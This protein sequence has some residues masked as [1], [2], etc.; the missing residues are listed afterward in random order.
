M[1]PAPLGHQDARRYRLIDTL[2]RFALVIALAAVL[3]SFAWFGSAGSG[4]GTV[5]EIWPNPLTPAGIW[6]NGPD[7][8]EI[9]PNTVA[10]AEIWPNGV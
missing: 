9:R 8:T 1:M 7:P 6:P 2:R 5:A 4:L 3:P 10:P